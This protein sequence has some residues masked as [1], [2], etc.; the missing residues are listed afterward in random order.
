MSPKLTTLYTLAPESRQVIQIASST[1]PC[2]QPTV[3][4]LRSNNGN[5]PVPEDEEET[6]SDDTTVPT[7]SSLLAMDVLSLPHFMML[8]WAIGEFL[9]IHLG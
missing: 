3:E 5:K 1:R 4:D 2:M 7:I 8:T 9:I 6:F